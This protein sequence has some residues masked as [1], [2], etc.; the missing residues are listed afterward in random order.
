MERTGTHLSMPTFCNRHKVKEIIMKTLAISLT[1]ASL[2]TSASALAYE[3]NEQ[4]ESS[5]Q[6]Q[7]FHVAAAQARPIAT[8]I[9]AT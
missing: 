5:L 8:P 9:K 3:A 6:A 7:K 4:R 1:I 2:F